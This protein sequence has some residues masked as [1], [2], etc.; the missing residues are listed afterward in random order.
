MNFVDS[1]LIFIIHRI[2]PVSH[3]TTVIYHGNKTSQH[4]FSEHFKVPTHREYREI[5]VRNNFD[6]VTYARLAYYFLSNRP[7][8]SPPQLMSI[9]E[10]ESIS[11]IISWLPHGRGFIIRDKGRFEEEV[12]T[13]YFKKTH[14]ASFTRRLNRWNFTIQRHGHKKSS[15]F[16]RYAVM[17]QL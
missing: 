11:D 15:Y 5:Y 6:H 12:L 4:F 16:Q 7:R 14:Y 8:D 13:K 9:L 10:N 1:T 17:D 2:E 3:D